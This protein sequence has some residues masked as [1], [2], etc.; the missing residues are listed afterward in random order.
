MNDYEAETRGGVMNQQIDELT[1][2]INKLRS[3][4][5]RG[6]FSVAV[7]REISIV[8]LAAEKL[9][10][11][12]RR[13]QEEKNLALAALTISRDLLEEIYL[14]RD[15]LQTELG[16][17]QYRIKELQSIALLLFD[18]IDDVN[19]TPSLGPELETKRQLVWGAWP[20]R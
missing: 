16:A 8:L 2:R 19:G 18:V 12:R 9:L 1:P 11:E 10:A 5:G 13:I 4:I 17:A 3:K 14:E 7:D 20:W 15:N 6:V